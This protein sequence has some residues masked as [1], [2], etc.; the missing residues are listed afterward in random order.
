[1]LSQD[2]SSHRAHLWRS[3]HL[4]DIL[5]EVRDWAD[6]PN[7]QSWLAQLLFHALHAHGWDGCLVEQDVDS[8]SGGHFSVH[9]LRWRGKTLN[10]RQEDLDTALR[11]PE[12]GHP[13]SLRT[14]RVLTAP[15]DEIVDL[16]QVLPK[17]YAYAKAVVEK[18]LLSQT[19]HAPEIHSRPTRL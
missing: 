14:Q 6:I 2:D 13:L 17:D 8:N 3:L 11:C 16:T 10:L 18:L 5:N 15:D 9:F 7:A 1:M 4:V 12:L 19:T